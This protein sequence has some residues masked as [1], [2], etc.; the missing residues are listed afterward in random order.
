LRDLER[1]MK[2]VK[3]EWAT[4]PEEGQGRTSGGFRCLWKYATT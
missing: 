4:I 1:T 2:I 3:M